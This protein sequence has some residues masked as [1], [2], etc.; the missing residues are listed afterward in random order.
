MCN[1]GLGSALRL[2]Y[3]TSG[4]GFDILLNPVH[5]FGVR[6]FDRGGGSCPIFGTF[7]MIAHGTIVLR[8]VHERG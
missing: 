2:D 4:F 5:D 1:L 6:G 3:F 7:I 8:N